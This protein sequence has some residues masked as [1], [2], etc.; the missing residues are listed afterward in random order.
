M[1]PLWKVYGN[2]SYIFKYQ[3]LHLN[4]TF[5]EQINKAVSTSVSLKMK[6]IFSTAL[7][8]TCSIHIYLHLLM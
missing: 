3:A 6:D 5:L 2:V 8:P 4:Q 7:L 1:V